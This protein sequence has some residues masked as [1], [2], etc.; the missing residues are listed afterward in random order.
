[1]RGAHTRPPMKAVTAE[2]RILIVEYIYVC[3]YVRVYVY[4]A[5]VQ[6]NGECTCSYTTYMHILV[7]KTRISSHVRRTYKATYMQILVHTPAGT[8]RHTHTHRGE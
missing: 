3:M 5:T 7:S 1:M 4:K 2:L 8:Q 6:T